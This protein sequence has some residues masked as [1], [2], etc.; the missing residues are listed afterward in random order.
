M[1]KNKTF[2]D[3]DMA[4]LGEESVG[5]DKGGDLEK[6]KTELPSLKEMGELLPVAKNPYLPPRYHTPLRFPMRGQP[7]MQGLWCISP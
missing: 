6:V 4:L 7:L 5:C 2:E 3:Q 1:D